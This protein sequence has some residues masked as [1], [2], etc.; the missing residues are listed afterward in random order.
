MPRH[1]C[2]QLLLV[3]LSALIYQDTRRWRRF[4]HKN[5]SCSS[6]EILYDFDNDKSLS[7]ETH[8]EKRHPRHRAR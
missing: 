7:Y 2:L 6:L 5:P 1:H 8:H 3:E 4:Y